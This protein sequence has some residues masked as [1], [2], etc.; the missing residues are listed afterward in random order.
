MQNETGFQMGVIS[1]AKII[2][3]SETRES[4]V[5]SIQSVNASGWLLPPQIIHAVENYQAHW[6]QY[7]LSNYR[8]SFCTDKEIIPLYIPLYSSHLLQPLDTFLASNIQSRFALTG[9][10][11]LSP[12]KVLLKLPIKIP[13]PPSTAH[14]NI[15]SNT[16]LAQHELQQL[17]AGAEY[18]KSKQKQPRYFIQEGGS[19]NSD[20]GKQKAQE[21]NCHKQGHN[22]RQCPC[23]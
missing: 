22:R 11:P 2:C 1:T 7:I 18:Q 17:R 9:L 14:S 5:K 13:T 15:T 16:L 3:G 4:R 6:Y 21:S 23:K 19:L 20:Q 12:E 10:I 8:V